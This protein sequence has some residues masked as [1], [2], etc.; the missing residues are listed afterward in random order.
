M[1][2]KILNKIKE[3]DTI[4]IHRHIR[5]DGD[6]IGSQMG[7]KYYIEHNFP[8][9]KV[10]AVGDAIPEYLSSLGENSQIEDDIYKEALVIV[11]DTALK[12]RICDSRYSMG[13][14]IIKIDH[15]D[16]TESYA[17]L[18]YVDE[19]TPAC[20]AILTKMMKE[21]EQFGLVIP[22]KSAT[23]LYTGI[24]TDTGRFRFR[25]V[26]GETLA[27]AGSL[28][29]VGVDMEKI[30]SRLYIKT[31]K[32]LKLQGYVYNHFKTTKNG[33][34]YIYFS[35]DIMQKYGVTKEEAANL[36]NSLDSIKGSLIWVA[37]IDQMLPKPEVVENPL[38]SPENEIRVRIRSRFVAINEVGTHF[39]G[40]GHLQA[41]GATIYSHDEMKKLLKELDTTLK[42]YK[43]EHPEVF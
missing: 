10:Y 18:E 8:N 22:L 4:I 13:K 24:I 9:K 27:N 38:E 11:V 43:H 39:R 2:E 28:L 14:F 42:N 31:D 20:S 40:G 35:K 33:V 21:W 3:F 6:C 15:H 12:I 1:F 25:G 26:T 7:L 37:F 19:K 23:A 41:A 36:V 29:D 32:E 17:N 30:F 5:P 34:A 16:D